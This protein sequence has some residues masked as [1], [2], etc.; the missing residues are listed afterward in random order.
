MSLVFNISHIN[1]RAHTQ[2]LALKKYAF[3]NQYLQ[4]A[5]LFFDVYYNHFTRRSVGRLVFCFYCAHILLC[6]A[7]RSKTFLQNE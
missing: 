7:R 5:L 2:R 4:I 1:A 6:I 3:K